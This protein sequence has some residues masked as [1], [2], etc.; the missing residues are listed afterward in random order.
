MIAKYMVFN[1]ASNPNA[2][3]RY[4]IKPFEFLNLINDGK[5]NS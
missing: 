3:P 4:P 5:T 1:E 2:K